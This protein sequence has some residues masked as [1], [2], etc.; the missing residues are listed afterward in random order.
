MPAFDPDARYTPPE[1]PGIT[2]FNCQLVD[3]YEIPIL[4][5]VVEFNALE[6]AARD[7]EIGAMRRSN[8][9]STVAGLR[10]IF[11]DGPLG[12]RP[13]PDQEYCHSKRHNT[14]RNY[15]KDDS[16][17]MSAKVLAQRFALRLVERRGRSDCTGRGG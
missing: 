10:P 15:R 6:D 1:N 14:S 8:G 13:D 3:G 2:A 4:I 12:E 17:S 9:D 7:R 11:Y 16:S 5:A